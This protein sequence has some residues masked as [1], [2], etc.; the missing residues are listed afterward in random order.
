VPYNGLLVRQG[1]TLPP[2]IEQWAERD[3]M[4][5]APTVYDRAFQAGLKTAEVDWVAVTKAPTI[6]W[7]YPELPNP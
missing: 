7:S 3:R 4:V 1:P 2:K 6:H 5:F